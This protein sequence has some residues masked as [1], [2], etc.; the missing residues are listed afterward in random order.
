MCSSFVGSV[1]FL[2]GRD[3]SDCVE[4]AKPVR[5]RDRLDSFVEQNN[6]TYC[7]RLDKLR[8][9]SQI[10]ID[11]DIDKLSLGPRATHCVAGDCRSL[12]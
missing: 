11:I 7:I 12:L 10:D 1:R 8:P 6:C 9:T 2:K 4:A 3:A 5:T